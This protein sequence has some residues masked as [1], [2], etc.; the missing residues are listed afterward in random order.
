MRE[1]KLHITEGLPVPSRYSSSIP[2]KSLQLRHP[3]YNTTDKHRKTV[4][5]EEESRLSGPWDLRNDMAVIFLIVSH[6]SE[7]VQ[8]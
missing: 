1:L 8:D 6:I 2:C 3:G 5:G 7:M 4:K